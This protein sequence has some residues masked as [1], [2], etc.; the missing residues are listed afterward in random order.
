[1][2]VGD[3]MWRGTMGGRM[4]W[5]WGSRSEVLEQGSGSACFSLVLTFFFML[6]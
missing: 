5:G 3:S 2:C 6:S 1:M 4:C